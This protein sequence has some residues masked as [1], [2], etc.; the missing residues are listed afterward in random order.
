M[1]C[2]PNSSH[3]SL[4]GLGPNLDT[5]RVIRVRVI[6]L[7]LSSSSM[8]SSMQCCVSS[9]QKSGMLILFDLEGVVE[10]L[11]VD[12]SQVAKMEGNLEEM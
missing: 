12:P 3:R 6:S 7:R 10:T 11:R 9:L 1:S 4:P 8:H 2:L 5:S